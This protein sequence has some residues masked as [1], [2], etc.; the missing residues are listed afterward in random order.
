MR[1]GQEAVVKE[2]G[3]DARQLLVF[4]GG[5]GSSLDE[6]HE[7]LDYG[8]VKM[9]IDTDTQYAYARPVVDFMF[10]NYDQVLKVE[11]EVGSKKHYDPR[12]WM[13]KAESSMKDR[14]V[15]ACGDL[16]SQGKSLQL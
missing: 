9:N 6:I 1:D 16:K 2:F 8:V 13:K 3:E 10:K 7:T 4:H 12:V 14:I 11:G 15:Q 5:S